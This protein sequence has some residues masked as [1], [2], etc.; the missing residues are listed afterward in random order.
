MVLPVSMAP[1]EDRRL[2]MSDTVRLA[3]PALF[4]LCFGVGVIA[5]LV[6]AVSLVQLPFNAKPNSRTYGLLFFT[7]KLTPRGLAIRRRLL[8]AVA[9]FLASVLASI[10]TS[11]LAKLVASTL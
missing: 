5:W 7:D 4:V 10:A 8:I 1:S 11:A 6:A 2:T 9:V 3:L